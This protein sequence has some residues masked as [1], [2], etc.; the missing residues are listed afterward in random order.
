MLRQPQEKF[1]YRGP[2]IATES[3]IL[4]RSP[5]CTCGASTSGLVRQDRQ[6]ATVR[7]QLTPKDRNRF[8]S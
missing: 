6:L 1:E 3:T 2:R 5:A 4:G 7:L 8:P